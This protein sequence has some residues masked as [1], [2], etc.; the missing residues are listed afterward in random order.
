MQH[1]LVIKMSCFHRKT[2]IFMENNVPLSLF[3]NHR[4]NCAI[5]LLQINSNI[6]EKLLF[7]SHQMLGYCTLWELVRQR[8][9]KIAIPLL[10]SL[11]FTRPMCSS[12]LI[13]CHFVLAV[14]YVERQEIWP[15]VTGG[16]FTASD[17][18]GNI[19]LVAWLLLQTCD[20]LRIDQLYS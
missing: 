9:Q 14:I 2:I 3:S 18:E 8:Q 1:L 4:I 16:L 13:L 11:R 17:L 7:G 20:S 10:F 15:K 6:T 19:E 12:H 5:N